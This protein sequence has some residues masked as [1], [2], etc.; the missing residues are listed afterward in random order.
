[1]RFTP[2]NFARVPLTIEYKN[3]LIKEVTTTK[4]LG[5]RIDTNMN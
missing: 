3:I 5:M 2:A 1:M 4:L